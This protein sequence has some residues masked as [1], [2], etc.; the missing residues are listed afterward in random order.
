LRA[1]LIR[2]GDLGT[3]ADEDPTMRAIRS[4]RETKIKLIQQVLTHQYNGD[5]R[6]TLI[7]RG[8]VGEFPIGKARG[9]DPSL[10][11]LGMSHSLKIH[12]AAMKRVAGVV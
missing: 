4:G 12:G 1:T 5:L 10:H 11:E 8:D 2:R 3:Y 7:I 6:I 9:Q